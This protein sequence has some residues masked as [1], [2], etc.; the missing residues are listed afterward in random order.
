M[1]RY[2]SL[3]HIITVLRVRDNFSCI[4]F[5]TTKC[6]YCLSFPLL[7]FVLLVR[8]GDKVAAARGVQVF[9]PRTAAAQTRRAERLVRHPPPGHRP[10]RLQHRRGQS[11]SRGF[12]QP[13][14]GGGLRVRGQVDHLSGDVRVQTSTVFIFIVVPLFVWFFDPV[15]LYFIFVFVV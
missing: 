6:N 9:V 15:D 2:A 5:L 13:N 7:P 14:I 4:N 8:L 1:N 11:G 3:I 10:A 12:L